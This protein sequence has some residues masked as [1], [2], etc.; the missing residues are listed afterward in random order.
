MD[1]FREKGQKG[2]MQIKNHNYLLP[3]SSEAA[4]GVDGLKTGFIN[5]SGFCLTATCLRD[6]RRLV[7]VVTGYP[8]R[9]ERD[10]FVRQLLDWGYA[11]AADP[12]T[13]LKNDPKVPP[14]KAA[15]RKT[16]AKK[17]TVKQSAKKTTVRKPAV[18]KKT[19]Q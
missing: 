17:K 12:A 3:G 9:R 2:Y 13:A 15:V 19:A 4:E 14:R 11:R 7:A 1:T 10:R 16:S 6:G 5:R 18:K 8:I